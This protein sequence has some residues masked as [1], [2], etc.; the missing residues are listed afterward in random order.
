MW[1]ARG[2]ESNKRCCCCS[3]TCWVQRLLLAACMLQVVR[4]K[5]AGK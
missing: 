5:H 4:Q 2:S 1:G 3:F